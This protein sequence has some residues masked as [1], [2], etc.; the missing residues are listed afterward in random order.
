MILLTTDLSR[1][2]GLTVSATL[3]Y[4]ATLIEG[5]SWEGLDNLFLPVA[6]Y[7]LLDGFLRMDAAEIAP[8]V[9]L[10]SAVALVGLTALGWIVSRT[11]R[12][13]ADAT[14]AMVAFAY[15]FWTVSNF[16]IVIPGL[17]VGFAS[18]AASLA[19]GVA[20]PTDIRGR[21]IAAVCAPITGLIILATQGISVPLVTASHAGF[22]AAL[23]FMLPG[24]LYRHTER[25]PNLLVGAALGLASSLLLIGSWLLMGEQAG[26]PA[27][28]ATAVQ[29]LRSGLIAGLI[30]AL[31]WTMR[32][33]ETGWLL[34]LC[35]LVSLAVTGS[36][37]FVDGAIL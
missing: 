17:A 27:T 34:T 24:V 26:Q 7:L 33:S 1:V 35:A 14:M 12:V 32:L 5:A 31:P 28:V 29:M 21:T 30:G 23:G 2:E 10:T 18:V 8:N 9:G 3:A 36:A 13:P 20:D 4:V 19:W 37:L 11:S 6:L 16:A 15:I 25:K 22:A